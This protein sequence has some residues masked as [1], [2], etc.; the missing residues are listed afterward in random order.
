[1]KRIIGLLL[2]ICLAAA[3]LPV[4]V[5]AD[6]NSSKFEDVD[7]SKWYAPYVEYVV[8]NGYMSGV[9]ETRFS[10]E[11]QITRA[12]YVQVLYALEGKPETSVTTPF[13]DLK[14]NAYYT[15]AVSWAY[16]TGVTG[17]M[18]QNSF[19]PDQIVTREQAVTFYKAYAEKVALKETKES[20]NLTAFS[21]SGRIAGYAINPM[22]WAV[23]ANIVSGNKSGN[24]TI[25]DPKG[26]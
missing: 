17:G 4:M 20:A 6:N 25:L 1:M 5:F 24:N 19:G 2:V 11:T 23:G 12:Q 26:R 14:R 22:K 16:K 10:P 7:Q 13:T 3:T 21:D 15:N 9:S 18:T 8:E